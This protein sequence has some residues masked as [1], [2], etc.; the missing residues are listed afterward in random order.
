MASNHGK[1]FVIVLFLIGSTIGF[2]VRLP[3]VFSHMDKE[4][5][6]LFYCGTFLL[7][8]ILYPKRWLLSSFLLVLFG[9]LIEYAQEFSNRITLRMIGKRIHGR[10]DPEDIK[11]NL[12]G[13]GVGMVLFLIFHLISGKTKQAKP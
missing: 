2:M 6:A 3:R 13:L 7:L 9:V 8:S 5:H 4:L 12:I 10:F 1:T 11:F